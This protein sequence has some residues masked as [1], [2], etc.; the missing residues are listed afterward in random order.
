MVNIKVTDKVRG[1]IAIQ[2]IGMNLRAGQQVSVDEQILN[3]KQVRIAIK[4][5]LLSVTQADQQQQFGVILKNQTGGSMTIFGQVLQSKQQMFTSSFNAISDPLIQA[6]AARGLISV[7]NF[8]T[9]LPVQ[10]QVLSKSQAQ[11]PTQSSMRATVRNAAPLMQQQAQ[12]AK[13]KNQP[14]TSMR[15]WDIQKKRFIQTKK[16]ISG[17]PVP[18]S[19]QVKFVDAPVAQVKTQKGP[20]Q[21]V[22]ISK[23]EQVQV[24]VVKQRGRPRKVPQKTQIDKLIDEVKKPKAQ[25]VKKIKKSDDMLIQIDNVQQSRGNVAFVDQTQ[26]LQRVLQHPKLS[27]QSAYI[28]QIK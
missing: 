10:M 24:K 17:I 9:G 13:I 28:K 22:S 14:S 5:G 12:Q 6:S 25:Q 3:N 20:Q 18:Q 1:W 26:K 11:S 27:K 19:Q 15:V 21:K 8:D 2:S 4:N 23:V 7:T 16:T